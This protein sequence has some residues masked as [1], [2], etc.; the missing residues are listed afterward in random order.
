MDTREIILSQKHERDRLLSTDYIERENLESLKTALA[1]DLIKVIIG[2]RRAGKSVFAIEALKGHDFAYLNFDD[3]RLLG[4]TD[5]DDM[6]KGI[7]QVYGQTKALFFDEIQNLPQWELFLNRLQ[8]EGYNLVITGSNSKLLSKELATHLT[9]RFQQFDIL[10][11]SFREFLQ[12]KGRNAAE[13][14]ETKRRQGEL[15][16]LLSEYL[17]NGGYPEIVVKGVDY[18]EYLKMIYNSTLMRD[19]VRR[20]RVRATDD[21]NNIGLYLITNH[22][23]PISMNGV[24]DA[25]GLSSTTTVEKYVRY[26]TEAFLLFMVDRFSYKMKERVKSQKKVYT[27]DTGMI[28]AVTSQFSENLGRKMENAVAIELLR[29]RHDGIFYYKTTDGKE[30]DFVVKDGLRVSELIQVCY[31]LS[32]R[33]TRTREV[34][35]LAKAATEI[36]CNKNTLITWDEHGSLQEH[37]IS[38]NLV[39]LREWLLL[40]QRHDMSN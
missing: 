35:A 30:V 34:S 20:Y 10:P 31:N 23:A 28:D 39:P 25:L 26:L 33:K 4:I 24:K 38:I 2:P 1:H 3:E 17:Q 12:A 14:L 22:S 37:G 6:L 27:Y 8:R 11:F 9:G 13:D 16:A 40:N 21:L 32:D 19:I 36:D 5:Y 7:P 15:L 29:Q 18:R